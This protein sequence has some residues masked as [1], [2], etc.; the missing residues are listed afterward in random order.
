VTFVIQQ[1]PRK[2]PQTKAQSFQLIKLR[3][4]HLE[5]DIKVEVL[6]DGRT[7]EEGR[8]GKAV[9]VARR[10]G[11]IGPQGAFD[12]TPTLLTTKRGKEEIVVGVQQRA[13][14]KGVIQ[15]QTLYGPNSKP[16][17]NSAYGRGTTAQDRFAGNTTLGFHE[18]CHRQDFL[19]YLRST[20]FPQHP[21]KLGLTRAAYI[22]AH[23]RFEAAVADYFKRMNEASHLVTDETG[24]KKSTFKAQGRQ[25]KALGAVR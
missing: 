11:S 6:P 20:P 17:G 25:P 13:R 10:I 24:Y 22:A 4:P 5:I 1:K 19:D 8:T 16:E 18:S 14:V 15:I 12:D 2:P 9:T 23:R 3:T 7:N 21:G